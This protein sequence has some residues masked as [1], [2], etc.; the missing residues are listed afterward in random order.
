MAKKPGQGNGERNRVANHGRGSVPS[1]A[2]ARAPAAVA[3][4]SPSRG[5]HAIVAPESARMSTPPSPTASGLLALAVALA[6]CGGADEARPPDGAGAPDA[7]AEPDASPPDPIRLQVLAINDF[8]GALEPPAGSAGRVETERPADMPPVTVDAGGAA[9]LAAHVAALRADEP[10]TIVVSAGDLIGA[11]PLLSA[12]FH[13]EPTIEAMNLVGLDVNAVGNHEF[14]EGGAE[15]LR[16]QYGGCHPTDGCQDGDGF[17]GAAFQFLAANVAVEGA[18]RT[19]LPAYTIREYDG[20]PVAF[21]GMTLENTPEIVTPLGIGGLAFGDE[22]AT[23]NELVPALRA[24]GVEAIVVLI[25]EGGV[26]AGL[27]DECVG[28]SG[29]IVDIV[30]ALDDEVDLVV[31]GH[32]HAAYNCEIAGTR[33]TSALSNG[34]LLTRA[35]LELDPRTRDVVSVEAENRIVTRDVLPAAPVASLIDAYLAVIAPLRDRVVGTTAAVVDRVASPAG[36]SAMGSVIAD[37]QLAATS[38][39]PLGGAQLALMNP[40]GVRADLD[41]GPVT[42]GEIFTVQPFG[43]SLVTMTLTGAQIEAALEQQWQATTTRILQPSAGFAYTWSASGPVGDKVDPA[44]LTLDGQPVDPEASYRVTVNSFLASGG[45]GFTVFA[46]GTD[47]LGGALDLD[48][49]EA[50]LVANDPLSSPALDRIAV[51]P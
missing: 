14:D 4:S 26:Q 36:Q 43:N 50:Y 3:W 31:T 45:D 48:A 30:T 15:L 16:M 29:P 46:A 20:V 2:R 17:A 18:D 5:A 47:R 6:A 32:T 51:I 11:S 9:Y 34:R 38:P 37:A 12:A 8:H 49:L 23:V 7:T 28:I 24:E 41:A 33:V 13:D 1:Q 40:G 39:A 42:F 27:Y 25:H 10:H 21:I 35:I 44:S 19:L 22:A